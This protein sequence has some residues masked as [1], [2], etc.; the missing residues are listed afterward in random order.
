MYSYKTFVGRCCRLLRASPSFSFRGPIGRTAYIECNTTVTYIYIICSGDFSK[1]KPVNSNSKKDFCATWTQKRPLLGQHFV[2][3]NS[4]WEHQPN[5]EWVYTIDNTCISTP[6]SKNL[7]TPWLIIRQKNTE[8]ADKQQ[9]GVFVSSKCPEQICANW[10]NILL[11]RLI[12]VFQLY[13]HKYLL[14]VVKRNCRRK[15]VDYQKQ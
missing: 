3:R 14:W 12:N 8:G 15:Q 2:D 6:M 1:C 9:R 7:I 10:N 4:Q 11:H 5:T 13:H